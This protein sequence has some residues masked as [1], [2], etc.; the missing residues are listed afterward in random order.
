ML[1][2]CAAFGLHAGGTVR[3]TRLTAAFPVCCPSRQV[4]TETRDPTPP[5]RGGTTER[6]RPTPGHA[7]TGGRTPQKGDRKGATRDR[8]TRDRKGGPPGTPPQDK[9]P[10][11]G[12]GGHPHPDRNTPCDLR[13][14]D[15]PFP[16][17]GKERPRPPTSGGDQLSTSS[18]LSPP[19]VFF[20]VFFP[21]G[22]LLIPCL[23]WRRHVA[24][25][26]CGLD[27]EQNGYGWR[28]EGAAPQPG[29][30]PS[31]SPFAAH[32]RLR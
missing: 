10:K 5:Q 12:N 24:R 1:S 31:P 28:T 27:A 14:P 19:P 8:T 3:S 26:T 15:A 20:F 13:A 4:Y 18:S 6:G 17:W 11:G 29:P 7:P 25:Q 23:T 16:P 22:L 30:R 21:S 9:T 32:Q 2:Y